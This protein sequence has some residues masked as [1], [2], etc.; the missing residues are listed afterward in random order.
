MSE[1]GVRGATGSLP[2]ASRREIRI[3]QAALAVLVS[4]RL[5][6]A[7]GMAPIG[8]EA[9]Y[10]LW[11][12][13]PDLSY[14]D[15]PPLNAWLQGLMSVLFGW[16]LFSLRLLGWI[17]SGATVYLLY[18][19]SRRLYGDGW[20]RMFWIGTL[21]FFAT[22]LFYI[23]SHMMFMDH[24]LIP[25]V[26]WSLLHFSSFF[27]AWHRGEAR[28][29]ELYIAAAIMG[30]AA[31]TKYNA[32]FLAAGVA[33]YILGNRRRRQLLFRPQLYLAALTTIA[34]LTPVIVWNFQHKLASISY[35]LVERQ[36]DLLAPSL[37]NVRVFVLQTLLYLSPFMLW[38]LLK[39][40][41][42]TKAEPG[43]SRAALGLARM[44]FAVSTLAVL[45][46]ASIGGAGAYWNIVAY[47]PLTPFMAA[48]MGARV[49]LALHYVYCLLIVGALGFNYV[50]APIEAHY[51][52]PDWESSVVHGWDQVKSEVAAAE[53]R[54]KP[55]FIAA[56]RYTLAAQLAFARGRD[57]V[58][59]LSSRVDQFDFWWRPEEHVGQTAL[60]LTDRE[61]PI[62]EDTAAQFQ[63]IEEVVSFDIVRLGR[64]I[65]TF[66]LQLARGYV[67]PRM[68]TPSNP[69]AP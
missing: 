19:W 37:G 64:V 56:T 41:A 29:R 60:I 67:A 8:D 27:E 33:L 18:L 50:V 14:Y 21:A 68:M 65:N 46:I 28:W 58:T 9:Y 48:A 53:A 32:V 1:V 11:G 16:N 43:F 6:L 5:V 4:L 52:T 40:L 10:W 17:T 66:R 45:A 35:N 24:L 22:P 62:D 47:V 39:V 57:D 12:Q 7:L 49:Q 3:L 23:H 69:A 61:N 51:R 15:H 59:S 63:S 42:F 30:L 20:E 13:H 2:A 44:T 54:Y 25:L 36:T 55:D 38:P 26:L 34:V 31:L